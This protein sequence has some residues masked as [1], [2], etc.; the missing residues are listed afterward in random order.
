MRVR[1]SIPEPYQPIHDE[2]CNT[3]SNSTSAHKIS[4]LLQNLFSSEIQDV[5]ITHQNKWSE[6]TVYLNE[7]QYKKLDDADELFIPQE[8]KFTIDSHGISFQEGYAPSEITPSC[9]GILM[10]QLFWKTIKVN[11]DYFQFT[12]SKSHLRMLPT[13]Y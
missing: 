4:N 8:L 6:V 13:I 10:N 5:K 7:E 9:C 1:H 11:G 2:L 12:T 3:V